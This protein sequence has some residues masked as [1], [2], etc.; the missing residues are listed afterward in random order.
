MKSAAAKLALA[1]TSLTLVLALS[2]GVLRAVAV[3]SPA[4]DKRGLH[5]AR[6]DRDWL[7]GLRPDT[8][9]MLEATGDVVYRINADGFR[10]QKYTWVKPQGTF[11][12]LVLGDSIAYGYGIDVEDS[13]PKIVERRLAKV[14]SASSVEVL[15]LGVSGYNPYT[16][17][18]LLKEMGPRYDP[19]LVIV[20]FCINDINDPTLHFDGHTRL[21]LGTIPDAAYPDPSMRRASV[22]QPALGLLWCH[23]LRLCSIVDEAI[24]AARSTE[25]EQAQRRA[26]V[27]PDDGGDS[28]VWQWLE[29]RYQEMAR[30]SRELGADFAVLAVPYPAQLDAVGLHP[31]RKRLLDL[32]EANDWLLID[33]LV[34][35]RGGAGRGERQFLDWWHPTAIGHQTIATETVAALVR[36][37]FAPTDS[38]YPEF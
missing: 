15:N 34:A 10:D 3:W 18:E 22:S 5:E 25:P 29:A 37:G 6:P 11:R 35:M 12:A 30:S 2:E 33:P 27:V 16:E 32:A 13:F 4:I 17:A 28:V 23:R 8:H 26:A 36:A 21:H 38:S 19:D 20:Q 14:I 7:Y 31:V 1:L 9:G 24:L